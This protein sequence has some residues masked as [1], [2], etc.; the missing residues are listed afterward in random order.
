[1]CKFKIVYRKEIC[2]YHNQQPMF[3]D[4]QFIIELYFFSSKILIE[5]NASII[6]F[7]IYIYIKKK[8]NSL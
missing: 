2:K 4:S 3:Q 6:I 8:Q 1:M 7:I 5:I